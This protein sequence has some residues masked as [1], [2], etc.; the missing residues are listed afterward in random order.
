[1]IRIASLLFVSLLLLTGCGANQSPD[2]AAAISATVAAINGEPITQEDLDFYQLINRLQIAINL[3]A[4]KQKLQGK[5]LAEAIKYWQ[6]L[7]KV[8]SDRNNLLTQIIRLRAVSL[9]AKEK[10]HTASDSEVE[11]EMQKVKEI[12]AQYP[13]ATD[14]IKQYGE[15]K[16]WSKQRSQ[17]Q[18]IVLSKK[19]QQDVLNTVK[20]ANP[21]AE[22]KEVN[23]LAQKKYEE[24]LVS[25]MGTL[26]IE[27]HDKKTE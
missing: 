12:Y 4:E 6:S 15:A 8:V 20:Q 21:Q 16:F 17:Y 24:L 10:G 18:M 13:V 1:M 5:E 19:V 11:N 9:L 25:Q 27:I 3:E 2:G 7:E 14:L 22:G 23:V 26:K